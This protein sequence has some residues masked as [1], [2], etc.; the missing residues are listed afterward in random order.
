[1]PWSPTPIA[2]ARRHVVGWF[3]QPTPPPARPHRIGWFPRHR[4]TATD[5]GIGQD[6][7]A[8]LTRTLLADTG[9]GADRATLQ[10]L[11]DQLATSAGIGTDTGLLLPYLTTTDTGIGQ[12]L[13]AGPVGIGRLPDLGIGQDHAA[14]QLRAQV[15]TDLGIGQDLAQQLRAR[16]SARPTAGVGAD[17]GTIGFTPQAAVLHTITTSGTIIHLQIPAWCRWI[18]G[19]GLGAGG[20]GAPGNQLGGSGAGADAG[21]YASRRWDRGVNRNNW[22]RVAIRAGNGGAQNGGNGQPTE[23][24]IEDWNGQVDHLVAPGGAGKTHQVALPSDREG[25]APGNHS[26]QGITATGGTG[27]STPP[28]SGGRGGGGTFWP[29]NPGSGDA[30]ARGQAWIRF[31]M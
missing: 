26:F 14:L 30:G 8:L 15:G 9:I 27:N 17:T 28:G 31:S 29:L 18:D 23:I 7:A 11:T 24:W 10:L 12:D 13:L 2:P 1:M 20:G 19:I 22:R 25:K 21:Q 4:L 6:L 16:L 3:P 5:T